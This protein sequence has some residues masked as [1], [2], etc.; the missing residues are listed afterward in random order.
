MV[1]VSR[2][3]AQVYNVRALEKVINLLQASESAKDLAN[4]PSKFLAFPLL[5]SKFRVYTYTSHIPILERK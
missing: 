4:P 2:M 3:T 1:I 5:T